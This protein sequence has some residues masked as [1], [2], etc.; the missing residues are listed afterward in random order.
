MC[1]KGLYDIM[2]VTFV[3]DVH[4]SNYCN[5]KCLSVNI[6]KRFCSRISESIARP[7]PVV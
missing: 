3:F 5:I 1:K 7:A 4:S 2:F 6:R